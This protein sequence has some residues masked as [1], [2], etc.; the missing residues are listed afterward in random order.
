[1][2]PLILS[3]IY[4]GLGQIYNRQIV[5][6]IDF[7]IIYTV[8]LGSLFLPIPLWRLAGLSLLPTMWFIGM[9]D[10]YLGEDAFVRR[11]HFLLGILPGVLLSLLVFYAQYTH[12]LPIPNARH[13]MPA[14][15]ISGRSESFSVRVAAFR[16]LSVA[17]DLKEE[18]LRKGYS[19]RI[20]QFL[21]TDGRRFRVLMGNFDTATDAAALARKLREQEEFPGAAVHR[22]GLE[23]TETQKPS[24]PLVDK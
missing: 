9:M 11:R 2:I 19:V 17:E 16:E 22:S 21:S 6:G 4:C 13:N 18:L 20:E 8:M 24:L 1:M 3:F 5:K 12:R 14:A 23:Q 15:A 10:A 7:I